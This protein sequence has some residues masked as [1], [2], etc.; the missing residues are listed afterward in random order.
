MDGGAPA[1]R[2]AGHLDAV[3]DGVRLDQWSYLN[4]SHALTCRNVPGVSGCNVFD[5]L[6][7]V[8]L[9][10][11]K[12]DRLWQFPAS[13]IDVIDKAYGMME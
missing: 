9:Q 5:R 7:I 3:I 1:H 2:R 8:R 6:R 4:L 10:H 11:L 13:L 12:H